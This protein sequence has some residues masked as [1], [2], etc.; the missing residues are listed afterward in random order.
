MDYTVIIS[1]IV[2]GLSV[3]AAAAKFIDWFLHSDPKTM[4]RTLRWML[5]LLV[6]AGIPLLV[7]MIMREQWAGAMLLGAGMLIVP[8]LLKWRAILTPLRAAFAQFRSKP[9][10]FEMPPVWEEPA[11]PDPRAVQ[12]AAALLEAYMRHVMLIASS[13][14]RI[15]GPPSDDDDDSSITVKE[16]LDVLGLPDGADLASVHAAHRRLMRGADPDAGGSPY[17]AAKIDEA[18]DV[19]VGALRRQGKPAAIEAAGRPRLLKG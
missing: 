13:Q 2:L 11:P 1:A 4:V 14:Q 7:M 5:L 17:L 9:Q 3:L 18:R 6:I 16:A 10:P 15:P 12:H 19:L 8:T